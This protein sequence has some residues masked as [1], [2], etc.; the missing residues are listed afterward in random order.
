MP[1]LIV[2]SLQTISKFGATLGASVFTPNS[3]QRSQQIIMSS[4]P[5]QYEGEVLR[6]MTEPWPK[7]EKPNE[8]TSTVNVF[9]KCVLLYI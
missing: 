9:Q 4:T 8:H 5:K 7:R 2:V 6:L 3:A 1:A